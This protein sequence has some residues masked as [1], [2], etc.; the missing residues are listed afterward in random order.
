MSGRGGEKKP[1]RSLLPLPLLTFGDLARQGLEAS[2]TCMSC[3]RTVLIKVTEQLRDRPVVSRERKFRCQ[4]LRYDGARC[5]SLGL[6]T[7][8]KAKSLHREEA[9]RSRARSRD[10]D[11]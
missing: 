3:H 4:G 8:G 10:K 1:E 11:P 2:I 7:I 6:L 5:S 9:R